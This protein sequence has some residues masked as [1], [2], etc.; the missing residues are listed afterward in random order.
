MA[1]GAGGFQFTIYYLPF[2]ILWW[3]NKKE[4]SLGDAK[5]IREWILCDYI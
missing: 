3:L 2:I 4:T 5:A 1:S